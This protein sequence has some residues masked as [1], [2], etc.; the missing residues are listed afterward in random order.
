MENKKSVYWLHWAH[1]VADNYPGFIAP[2]LPFLS[3]K[4]GIEMTVAT[5]II[6]LANIFSHFLQPVFGFFAD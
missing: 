6:S 4:I 3:A 5:F 1:F 2:I